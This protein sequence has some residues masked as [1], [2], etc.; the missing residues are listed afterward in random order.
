MSVN[1]EIKARVKDM[2]AL[3]Q[4]VRCLG[5]REAEHLCQEDTYF[6]VADGRLKLRMFDDG[7]GELIFYTR[8]AAAG[9]VSSTYFISRTDDP[10]SLKVVLTAALGVRGIVRK[11]RELFMVG[12]TR[13]HLDVVEGV[14]SFM[15][16]EVVLAPG[17]SDESGRAEAVALM[18][19]LCIEAEYLLEESYIDLVES[20]AMG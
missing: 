6:R 16:L 4:R 15:E 19:G 9:P 13:V 11:R 3:R 2:A 10:Q 12:R 17:E 18:D 1:T 20:H 14:G 8:A 5:D 7:R